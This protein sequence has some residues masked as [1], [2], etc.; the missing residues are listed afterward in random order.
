MSQRPI[1]LTLVAN[2]FPLRAIARGLSQFQPC[3]PASCGGTL[4]WW[5]SRPVATSQKLALCLP[6]S[7][8]IIIVP[9]GENP[10]AQKR[11]LGSAHRRR[12]FPLAR[13]HVL[14]SPLAEATL[15]P[16]G[17]KATGP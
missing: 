14:I 2:V 8:A 9:S 5:R 3:H 17:E 13:S 15:F 11:T 4:T 12:S 16:S 7:S 10:T 1:L 6:P